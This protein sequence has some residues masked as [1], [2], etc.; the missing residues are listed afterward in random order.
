MPCS[1]SNASVAVYDKRTGE[2]V[3]T[4]PENPDEDTV[5]NA[6][7]KNY[8]KSQFLL[9]YYDANNTSGN[10]DSY[11][12]CV[13]GGN[14]T[15]ES[16]ENGVRYLYTIGTVGESS[17]YFVIP[18]EYR[19]DG[20]AVEV[21]IPV[22]AIEEH[23]GSIYRIQLLRYMAATSYED[24]GYTVVPNGSGSLIYFNNG[25]NSAANYSQYIYGIDPLL[26]NY[27]NTENTTDARL[28]LFAICKE[29]TSV[30]ATV[31][32]GASLAL[33]TSGISGN[34][35]DLNYTYTTFVLR[36]ADNL[37][38]FGN[39]NQTDIYVLEDQLY[40]I[41]C[42]VRYT[43]LTDK[44]KGYSGVANYYRNRLIEEGKLSVSEESGDIPFYYDVLSGVR[45]TSHFL[46]VQYLRTFS[47][48]TFEQ[49]EEIARRLEEDGIDNQVMNLQGWFNGGYYN[50][51]TSRMKLVHKSG[52]RSDLSS[53]NETLSEIGGRL[54]ADTAFQKVS[55]AA[56]RFNYAAEG[57]RY[58]SGYVVSFGLTN[59]T[60]LRN[61]WGLGYG[62]PK[63]DLV[64]PRY[65]SRYVDS[66]ASKIDRYDVSGISLR[67]LGS[68][69][70]SDKKRTL[71]INREE[72]LAIVLGQFETLKETGKK[73]M[74]SSTNAYAFGYSDDIINA[75]IYGNDYRI[76]DE[77]IPLYGMI[78]HGCV[79][80]SSTLLN[81][82]D[83]DMKRTV[84]RMIE[85][86]ASPHYVF[87]Y[88]ESSLM[89][90]TAM[91][92]FYSTTFDVWEEEAADIYHQVN[93]VLQYVS[94]EVIVEHEILDS[95]VRKVTYSNG[96]VIYVNYSDSYKK[97]DGISIPALSCIV[98]GI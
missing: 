96:V 8:L 79:D 15:V 81:Y 16:I 41:N 61:T 74:T 13:A 36:N 66:F 97:A 7:N 83:T 68:E 19:L 84:L 48:T 52:S 91:N 44:Y 5:A 12:N 92:M 98:E 72:A 87:T 80:Y 59:P 62:E 31:E 32:E 73:L 14:F 40:D 85:N 38:M 86:G 25:K 64:S 11:S 4:N 28:P 89:K 3:R 54:Y 33:I 1:T 76:I 77:D 55:F 53:L 10:F 60:T 43:L 88:E 34:Y 9:Q 30:L 22:P 42:T 37:R 6:A 95:D 45:E 70:H 21:N 35:N 56:S 90:D 47:M 50:N 29:E 26:S 69:L 46:G 65:L 67:D 49:A 75:P 63:Y 57:S 71:I 2:I 82:D 39:N 94:G 58:Y 17:I 24:E 18:V 20:D 23:N 93:D 51:T 27:T 78:L